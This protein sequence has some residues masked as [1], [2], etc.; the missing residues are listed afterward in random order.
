LPLHPKLFIAAA[1]TAAAA[2]NR[3]HHSMPTLR[4]P[5]APGQDV[6]QAEP[7]AMLPRHRALR[8]LINPI[9]NHDRT[10]SLHDVLH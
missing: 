10:S 2:A 9:E 5:Q 3:T 4:D 1:S 8:D 6:S 7:E